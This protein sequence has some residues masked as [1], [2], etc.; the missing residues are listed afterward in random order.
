M[1]EKELQ[2]PECR[3]WAAIRERYEMRG[4]QEP[5][6]LYRSEDQKVAR[7][8]LDARDLGALEARP[9]SW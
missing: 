4:A 5:V 2:P 8:E 6:A 9:A 3:L 7:R 1:M